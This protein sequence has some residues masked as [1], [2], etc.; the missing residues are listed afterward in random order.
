MRNHYRK[1]QSTQ[2]RAQSHC[3]WNKATED[4]SAFAVSEGFSFHYIYIYL[5]I[6]FGPSF[7]FTPAQPSTCWLWVHASQPSPGWWQPCHQ[8]PPSCFKERFQ[9]HSFLL[10]KYDERVI[11]ADSEWPHSLQLCLSP[12]FSINR[13]DWYGNSELTAVISIRLLG[14]SYSINTCFTF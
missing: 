3:C 10:L 8:Q 6:F 5:F 9:F 13:A 2:Q 14:N 1:P 11:K 12:T 7:Y 4:N